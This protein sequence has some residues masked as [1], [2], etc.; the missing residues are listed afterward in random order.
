ME[1]Q[2]DKVTLVNLI[3]QPSM[4][5]SGWSGGVYSDDVSFIGSRSYMLSTGASAGEANAQTI[6]GIMLN[7]SHVYYARVYGYQYINAGEVTFL[8]PSGASAFSNPMPAGNT[9]EW[10]L[11]GALNSRAGIST[12]EYSFNISFNSSVPGTIYFDGC[13]LIDLTD[14]FGAGVEPDLKWC[15]RNILYFEGSMDIYVYTAEE[16]TVSEAGIVPNPVNAGQT[17][18]ISVAASEAAVF[19][20]PSYR[21]AGEFYAGEE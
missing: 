10:N 1:K 12:G 8:W 14:A 20:L 13:M 5:G 3:P 4:E 9:G 11:Y 7:P 18:T 2:L 21:Y 6:S 19:M 15:D 16:I 17:F